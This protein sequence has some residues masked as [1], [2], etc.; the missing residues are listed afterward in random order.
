ML[1]YTTYLTFTDKIL[2]TE[3]QR[4]HEDP[5]TVQ[6]VQTLASLQDAAHVERA[7]KDAMSE[8]P[9]AANVSVT[10]SCAL[11]QQQA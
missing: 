4:S 6:N 7:A 9:Y 3:W 5:H 10:T 11:G 1:Y 2:Y 8:H